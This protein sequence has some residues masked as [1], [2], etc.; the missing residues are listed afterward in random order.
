MNDVLHD[1]QLIK[2]DLENRPRLE[3]IYNLEKAMTIYATKQR[4]EELE[5]DLRDKA[6][7]EQLN[8]M[9]TENESIKKNVNKFASK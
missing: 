2:E 5:N 1:I 6:S 8:I 3:N 9:S 4:V 7:I